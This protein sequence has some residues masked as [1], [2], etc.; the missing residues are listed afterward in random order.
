MVPAGNKA[1]RHSS[2]NHTTK[3]I[4]HHHHHHHHRVPIGFVK[5]WSK[6]CHI[7]QPDKR[8]IPDDWA[9]SSCSQ[10]FFKKSVLEKFP[11]IHRKTPKVFLKHFAIF[12]GK[13]LCWGLFLIKLHCNFTKKDY[14]TSVFMW[15]LWNF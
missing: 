6:H 5:K 4:H 11:N 14:N 9:R 3:T 7:W 12:T 10:I 15:I 13:H 2:V 8:E 1:E